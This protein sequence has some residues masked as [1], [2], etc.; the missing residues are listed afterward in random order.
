MKPLLIIVAIL[1]AS[2]AAKS[3]A[4][5]DVS[6]GISTNL[7]LAGIMNAGYNSRYGEVAA[8]GTYPFMYGVYYGYSFKD[9]ALTPYL[10]Y[11]SNGI[12]GGLKIK[13]YD[14]IAFDL[15]VRRDALTVTFGY[16]I[17]KHKN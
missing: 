10:G 17:F 14:A 1:T 6:A 2:I 12:F 16:T 5:V 13:Y 9:G 11:S 4:F 7:G 8:T 15:R 3:Q